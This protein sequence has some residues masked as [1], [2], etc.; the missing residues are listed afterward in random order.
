MIVQSPHDHASQLALPMFRKVAAE[1]ETP[2]NVTFAVIDVEE[3]PETAQKLG[4]NPEGGLPA[5]ALSLKGVSTMV[6]YRGGWSQNSISA[7]LHKQVA[8]S[9][10]SVRDLDELRS[11]AVEHEFGLVVVGFLSKKQTKRRLLE[12]AARNAQVHAAIALGDRD[13]AA[14]L[15]VQITTSESCVLIVR[16][17]AAGTP[18]PLLCG[19]AALMSPQRLEAFLRQRALPPV[20]RIGDSHRTFSMQV[21]DHPVTL[22]VVLVHRSGARGYDATSEQ[23]LDAMH[24]VATDFEGR[25][26]FLSYDFFDNDPDQ[27]TSHRVFESQLPAVIVFHDRG[28]F[29]ERQWRLPGGGETGIDAHEIVAIVQ[30]ALSALGTRQAESERRLPDHAHEGETQLPAAAGFDRA[31]KTTRATV[32]GDG[33]AHADDDDDDDGEDENDDDL[34]DPNVDADDDR[35]DDDDDQVEVYRGHE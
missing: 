35:D 17:Q 3:A 9:P 7:W 23:A 30:Q 24:E 15:G 1:W 8:L 2:G 31:A 5:Y 26:L 27:F 14:H 32:G 19:S 16:A 33:S 10:V 29:K 11:V 12:S 21:R 34:D 25:A 28:G 6:R 20:I 18:W 13:L 4:I 22:Q